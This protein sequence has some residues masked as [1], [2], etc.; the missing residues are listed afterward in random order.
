M[1]NRR[2]ITSILSNC[3]ISIEKLFGSV[4]VLEAGRRVD[5][6]ESAECGSCR[7]GG[8]GGVGVAAGCVG[9]GG[10]RWSDGGSGVA[11]RRRHRRAGRRLTGAV[12]GGCGGGLGCRAAGARGDHG[13]SAHGDV[14]GLGEPLLGA[15][16]PVGDPLPRGRREDGRGVRVADCGRRGRSDQPNP[17]AAV[18]QDLLDAATTGWP[19]TADPKSNAKPTDEPLIRRSS[20]RRTPSPSLQL[21]RHPRPGTEVAGRMIRCSPRTSRVFEFYPLRLASCCGV[22]STGREDRW[23]QCCDI[24]H[25]KSGGVLAGGSVGRISPLT[26]AF[27]DCWAIRPTGGPHRFIPL[28]T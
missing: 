24:R 9:S 4:G 13:E 26:W 10:T 19:R 18:T 25:I 17:T 16:R 22:V 21:H 28:W 20:R 7:G 6:D 12:G 8:V 5:P 15:V 14:G 3:R 2:T 1:I 27:G 23:L 11:R